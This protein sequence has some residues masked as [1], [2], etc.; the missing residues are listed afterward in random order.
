MVYDHPADMTVEVNEL[1]QFNCT[2]NCNCTSNV[3]W[4]VA[5][6]SNVIDN[7]SVPGLTIMSSQSACTA[8]RKTYF[9]GAV[10]TKALEVAIYCAVY[11]PRDQFECSLSGTY[12]SRPA[13]LTGK[14]RCYACII[15][16]KVLN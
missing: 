6:R 14:S 13:L 2:V 8:G 16:L 15:H 5:G 11:E 9:F 3:G 7:D 4:Y 1:A 12:Y 10:A